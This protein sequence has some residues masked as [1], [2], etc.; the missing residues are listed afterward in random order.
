MNAKQNISS[1]CVHIL[2]TDAFEKEQTLLRTLT[3]VVSVWRDRW[4]VFEEPFSV[5][6]ELLQTLLLARLRPLKPQTMGTLKG[7]QQSLFLICHRPLPSPQT[8]TTFSLFNT[9]YILL[10]Y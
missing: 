1:V 4:S 9:S 6:T 7:H 10:K 3:S 5:S 8:C 2:S